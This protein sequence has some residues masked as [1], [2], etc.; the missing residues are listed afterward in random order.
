MNSETGEEEIVTLKKSE[1]EKLCETV[2]SL[3]RQITE[4]ERIHGGHSKT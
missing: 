2:I 4:L 1:F 3:K